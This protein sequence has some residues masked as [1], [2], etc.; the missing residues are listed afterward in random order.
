MVN[1]H[2]RAPPILQFFLK[3]PISTNAQCPLYRAL[4]LKNE[5]PPHIE[6][7]PPIEKLN[8]LPGNDSLKKNPKN[9]KLSLILVINTVINTH[10][11][12]LEKD[13]RNSTRM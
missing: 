13:G 11:T 8:S 6:K 10:K 5:A 9:R 12:T 2:G 7:Q 1:V 4:P 3:T